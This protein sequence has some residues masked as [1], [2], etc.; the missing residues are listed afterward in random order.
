MASDPLIYTL[1]V[2]TATVLI[3]LILWVAIRYTKDRRARSQTTT[4]RLQLEQDAAY[5]AEH[6][7]SSVHLHCAYQPSGAPHGSNYT[8][9]S[10]DANAGIGK[11]E[12]VE[13]RVLRK[14]DLREDVGDKAEAW[15]KR[16][17]SR[18]NLKT[19]SEEGVLGTKT[20]RGWDMMGSPTR[21]G[22]EGAGRR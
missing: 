21:Q 13:L 6:G 20:M 10:G 16:G 8:L 7:E 19:V 9:T 22:L 4:T 2:L 14:K 11:S 5:A 18:D 17:A 3:L 12:D 1:A 15:L